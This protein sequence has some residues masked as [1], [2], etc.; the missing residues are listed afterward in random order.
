MTT[1]S[2]SG[3]CTAKEITLISR[4]EFPEDSLKIVS[5]PPVGNDDSVEEMISPKKQVKSSPFTSVSEKDGEIIH[6]DS[7]EGY[8]SETN[9]LVFK[10]TEAMNVECPGVIAVLETGSTVLEENKVDAIKEISEIPKEG[11]QFGDDVP[12][13]VEVVETDGCVVSISEIQGFDQESFFPM[14]ESLNSEKK[15]HDSDVQRFLEAE[16]RRLLAEI[17]VGTIFKKKD[18]VDSLT[19]ASDFHK[20]E[21]NGNGSKEK[22]HEKMGRVRVKDNAFVGRSMKIEL[23]DDIALLDVLSYYKKGKD[24]PP[25]RLGISHT[26]KDAPRKHKKIGGEKPID[27]RGNASNVVERNASTKV[28]VERNASTKVSELGNHGETNGKQLRIMYSRNQME[29]MRY[30]HIA[31]QKKLWSDMYT[32]LLPELVTEYEG[33]VSL[34]SQKTS[35]SNP[36]ESDISILGPVSAVPRRNRVNV[37]VH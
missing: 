9:S 5:L 13:I 25:K 1:R 18:D 34:K 28:S 11:D 35:K 21:K 24:H 27:G 17:E 16:K 23:V 8:F 2:D 4:E 29:S 33:L 22:Q 3:E 31:N 6:S 26:D 19:R 7:V 10:E 36:R 20:I 15:E 32:R 14:K 30:G 37:F 12:K